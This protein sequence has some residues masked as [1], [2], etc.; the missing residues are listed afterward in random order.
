[1]AAAGAGLRGTVVISDVLSE[2]GEG[3]FAEVEEER[4]E[5]AVKA[6][7]EAKVMAVMKRGPVFRGELRFKRTPLPTQKGLRER[8]VYCHQVPFPARCRM[9]SAGGVSMLDS[10]EYWA[11]MDERSVVR[12]H[13]RNL[14][15]A[16]AQERVGENARFN[17]IMLAMQAAAAEPDRLKTGVLTTTA[18][19][20]KR[21]NVSFRSSDVLPAGTASHQGLRPTME[22]A[23]DVG[24][25][26]TYL[27]EQEVEEGEEEEAPQREEEVHY[28]A[29][30]D[31]HGGRRWAVAAAVGYSWLLSLRLAELDLYGLPGRNI[32]L[33]ISTVDFSRTYRGGDGAT[34]NV[35]VEFNDGSLWCANLGDSRA[36]LVTEIGEV[37][38]LSEDQKP[39]A[40]ERQVHGGRVMVRPNKFARGVFKRGHG[41]FG[42][43]VDGKLAVARALG[44]GLITSGR[45]KT[46]R[47]TREILE[48][49]LDRPLD[50]G[51]KVYLGQGCDGVFDVASTEQVGRLVAGQLA[52]GHT[53][54][55]VAADVVSAAIWAGTS[56]N[57]TFVLRETRLGR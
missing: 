18:R 27:G 49:V 40:E 43:R 28:S 4:R 44:D 15:A 10:L 45:S 37:V 24:S 3:A 46:T 19:H 13:A 1:M 16:R 5:A 30:F 25:I 54:A 42:R 51:E 35:C 8:L 22:D 33:K 12:R 53:C 55:R 36:F 6:A 32:A 34:A 48:A 41:V 38:Q 14:D 20:G 23:A 29:V 50:E 39:L 26:F 9:L 31:G 7:A 47:I 21:L 57:V 17:K 56:D 52:M 11:D 2:D